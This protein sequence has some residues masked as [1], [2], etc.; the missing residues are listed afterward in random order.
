MFYSEIPLR[1]RS[2]KDLRSSNP[3]LT[4]YGNLSLS[5]KIYIPNF[6]VILLLILISGFVAGSLVSDMMISKI[7]SNTRQS[8]DIVLESLDSGLTDVETGAIRIASDPLVQSVLINQDFTDE[9]P[10]SLELEKSLHDKSITIRN[11]VDGVV[12]YN[13]DGKVVASYFLSP[14]PFNSNPIP[15]KEIIEEMFKT[16]NN[17]KW[18]GSSGVIT[19]SVE[20]NPASGPF[21][22]HLIQHGNVGDVIGL[23]EIRMNTGIF[24]RLYSHLDYGK[25][26]RFIALNSQGQLVSPIGNDYGLYSAFLKKRY[27]DLL[28][29][30]S[31]QGQVVSFGKE[32]FVVISD[33]LDRLY[34]LIIG[35]VPLH[36]LLEYSKRLTLAIYLIG[37]ACILLE[38]AFS[39]WI[40]QLITKPIMRLSDSMVDVST[41]DLEIRVDVTSTDEIGRLSNNFNEMIERIA[42]LMDQVYKGHEK[43]RELELL[44]LQSQIN[45]HFL[46]NSLESLCSLSQ[47][48]RN[49]DAYNLGK[50]L[51]LFYRGVLSKGQPVITIDQEIE[52]IRNYFSI[53]E[54]RYLDKFS[55]SIKMD[56]DIRDQ[57]IIKLSLQPII[58]NSIYHGLKM[59]RKKGKIL[60]RGRR[61]GNSEVHIIVVD[62]G[63][64]IPESKAGG[65]LSGEGSDGSPGGFG[66]SSVDQRIKLFFGD[67]VRS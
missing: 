52:T 67:H 12:I 37:I 48:N 17:H 46:Y 34:W 18:I 16:E 21:L 36:E 24:T 23:V 59:V 7:I 64:G 47:L 19:D 63:I 5:R 54:F 10:S 39:V 66:L 49:E 60:I 30:S 40:S 42:G 6:V 43:Q 56:D 28:D 65:L 3:I 38:I 11:V 14:D 20:V 50:S 32:E 22:Y 15:A 62:N 27:S 33:Q 35:L 58:E 51:S 31:T 2:M 8:L 25:S 57:R 53:L 13:L 9:A 55:Y 61:A 41:G 45:P 29:S 4:W 44:A 1:S 26:G